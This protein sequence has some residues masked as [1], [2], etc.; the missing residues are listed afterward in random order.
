MIDVVAGARPNLL[1]VRP[2]LCELRRRDVPHRFIWIGQHSGNLDLRSE[3]E[4]PSPD[5]DLS[6]A[7]VELRKSLDAISMNLLAQWSKSRPKAVVVVGDVTSTLAAALSA[8]TLRIPIVHVEAGLRS[9]DL[10]MPEERNRILVDRLS[11]LC[12]CTEIAAVHN[13]L[14]ELLGDDGGRDG[15][16]RTD[17]PVN[18]LLTGNVM[19]D[20]LHWALERAKKPTYSRPYALV[21]IHRPS[22]VDSVFDWQKTTHAIEAILDHVDV[23]WPTHPRAGLLPGTRPPW[24]L[25]RKGLLHALDPQPYLTMVGLMRGALF[26]AT[27]SGG[28]QEETTALGIPCLTLRENTERPVTVTVGTNTLVGTNP[29]RIHQEVA[30]ILEGR[31]KRGSI[32]EGWD[33]HAAERVVDAILERYS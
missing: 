17:K 4:M 10:S 12:L 30:S 1:K 32:P 20:S 6:D 21:T 16:V 23:V 31:Y 27:D 11:E 14:L 15:C 13:V 9:G 3:L 25:G 18:A 8:A 7:P 33:G 2:I 19:V 26:V 28:I 22:N 29:D 24:A 5:V